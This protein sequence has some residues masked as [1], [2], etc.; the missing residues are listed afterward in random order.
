[1]TNT[2]KY[3]LFFIGGLALGGSAGYVS[4]KMVLEK[5]YSDI[6]DQQI[7]DMEEYYEKRMDYGRQSTVIFT[8]DAEI[9]DPED[10]STIKEKLI[11]NYEK[12]TNYASIYGSV[13]NDDEDDQD[14][15]KTPED[16]ANEEHQANKNKPPRAI[17][18]EE[19][20]N[21]PPYIAKET[22]YFYHYDEIIAD[23]NE[24]EV[25]NPEMLLGNVLN[26][27]DFH[28]SDEQIIFVMNYATDTVYEVQRVMGAYTDA[29]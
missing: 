19:Y 6:A 10:A 27:I 7:A 25:L 23:D 28:D 16:I 9:N 22:L 4:A 15:E 20:E 12:T 21:L 11:D 18:L 26:D 24:E 29:T 1:M 3:A 14:L 5:K 13:H 17:S 2:L 8:D